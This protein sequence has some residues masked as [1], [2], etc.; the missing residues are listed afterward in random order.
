MMALGRRA[1]YLDGALI[2]S[3]ASS[4]EAGRDGGWT[5][6]LG[7]LDADIDELL[8][9][10]SEANALPPAEDTEAPGVALATASST[11]TAPFSVAIEFTEAVSGIG[12]SDL[13]VGNGV[14]SAL[15]G[16]G[17]SYSVIVTPAGEGEVT[18]MLPAGAALDAAG[19][20]SLAASP[21]TV[22]YSL[23]AGGGGGGGGGDEENVTPDTIVLYHL[24]NDFL[25]ASPNGLH[26]ATGGG[27]ELRSD[28]LGWMQSPS[29]TAA[30]F[31]SVGDS[32]S[33]AIPDNLVL[34][35]ASSPLTIE[36]RVFV[37]DYLGYGVDNL[38]VLSLHQD[39][40]AHFQL[41]E[42]EMGK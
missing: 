39:W 6:T 2:N 37:R 28:N 16:G 30:D 24:N 13:D 7:N 27:V 18:I 42:P 15:S 9:S 41:D 20:P 38:P 3:L 22:D 12:L 1:S 14:A 34:A 19:N 25:D 31:S 33:V 10:R 26:L 36:A 23:P 5:L 40:D 17:A 32:L 21:L 29:G 4:P 35:D 8:I 11:V